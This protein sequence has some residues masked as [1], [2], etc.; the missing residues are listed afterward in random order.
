MRLEEGDSGKW[1]EM[2]G[3]KRFV[4]FGLRI[5]SYE[6]TIEMNANEE[7]LWFCTIA[8]LVPSLIGGKKCK[9]DGVTRLHSTPS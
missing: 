1:D 8:C 3:E 5:M 2:D 7:S 4:E 6:Y 9:W